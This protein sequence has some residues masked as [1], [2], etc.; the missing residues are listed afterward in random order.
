MSE[1]KNHPKPIVEKLTYKKALFAG[2]E[3]RWTIIRM[4]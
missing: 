2:D 3:G 1:A 4:T